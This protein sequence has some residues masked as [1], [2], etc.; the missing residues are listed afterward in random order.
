LNLQENN[1]SVNGTKL[2]TF[3]VELYTGQRN[4]FIRQ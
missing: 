1:F 3:A 4:E 2:T